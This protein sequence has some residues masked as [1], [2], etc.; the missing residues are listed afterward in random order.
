MSFD[1]SGDVFKEMVLPSNGPKG[2]GYDR[3]RLSALASGQ[4]VSVFLSSTTSGSMVDAG[5]WRCG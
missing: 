2:Y 5:L 4:T 1:M 3:L